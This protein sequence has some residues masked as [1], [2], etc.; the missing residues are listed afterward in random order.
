NLM[1]F[2]TLIMKV[3]GRSGVWYYGS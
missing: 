2:E 3:A 1:Q